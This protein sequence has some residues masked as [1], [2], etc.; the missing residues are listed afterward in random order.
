MKPEEYVTP[1]LSLI[2]PHPGKKCISHW[3]AN[4]TNTHLFFNRTH[5][6]KF[7]INITVRHKYKCVENIIDK[8]PD[9][10]QKGKDEKALSSTKVGGKK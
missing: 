3:T 9:D 1:N 10:L 5:R 2:G 4:R 7:V 6:Q 8:G